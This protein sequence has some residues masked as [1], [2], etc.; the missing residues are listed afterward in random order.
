M[1][2]FKQIIPGGPLRQLP[3]AGRFIL[4]EAWWL[5]TATVPYCPVPY[6][7]HLHPLPG[8]DFGFGEEVLANT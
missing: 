6:L 2:N 8:G 7:L 4:V 1:E 3:P 5:L